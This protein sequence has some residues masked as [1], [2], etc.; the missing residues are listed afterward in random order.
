MPHIKRLSFSFV[1][2]ASAGRAM[3]FLGIVFNFHFARRLLVGLM[4]FS[5][6]TMPACASTPGGTPTPTAAAVP[7]SGSRQN[8]DFNLDWKYLQ[9]DL[10]GADAKAFD[11]SKWT[12]VDPPHSTKF[13]TP[14]DPNAYLGVSWYRKHF[15]LA[16]ATQGK[17]VY[18]EFEAAMQSADV[19]VNGTLVGL[20]EGA[21]TRLERSGLSIR[22]RPVPGC[23]YDR[24][25]QAAHH[26]RGLCQ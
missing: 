13:V 16:S 24:D 20:H 15:T 11:D 5:P 10:S 22:R 4:V 9:G 17:K 12:Y 26:G 6:V 8:I 7:F 2:L 23:E 25:R 18:I 19:W 21:Q 14:E 3:P 1:H